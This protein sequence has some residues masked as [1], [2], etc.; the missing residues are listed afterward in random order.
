[1]TPDVVV[2]IGNT[3][4][5]WGRVADRM[6]AE[7]A[8]FDHD[9]AV[10]WKRKAELWGLGAGSRWVL[11]GVHPRAARRFEDWLAAREASAGEITHDVFSD[12][13]DE[14]FEFHTAVEEPARIGID[15]LLTSFAAWQRVARRTSVVVLNIGTAMTIDFVEANGEHRGGAILPG[16]RLMARALHERTAKLP[17]VEIDPDLPRAVWGAN[18]ESAIALGIANA[19]LG[20]A[21]Q[22]VW[23][24]AALKTRP[25]AVYATGGDVGYFHGFVFTADVA[26]FVIDSTLTLDGIRLAAEALP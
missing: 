3:R 4:M 15:R 22:M 9:D 1:V 16:P 14:R 20:A 5:K 18:T 7:V 8:A 23:D 12:D 24:W 19:V 13:L 11:A 2:D 26:R 17:L 21:D 10:G 25:P 6:I